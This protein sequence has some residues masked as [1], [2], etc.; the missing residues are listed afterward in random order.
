[1]SDD[2]LQIARSEVYDISTELD[3]QTEKYLSLQE[4]V[5]YGGQVLGKNISLL[6]KLKDAT[7]MRG[8]VKFI[9]LI[10]LV[11]TVI[12]TALYREELAKAFKR[13]VGRSV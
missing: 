12:F 1:M 4:R 9:G 13:H 7:H 3:L 8:I 10:F 11:T 6:N 5:G 2:L